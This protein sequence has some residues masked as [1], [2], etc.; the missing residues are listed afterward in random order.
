MWDCNAD[1]G[2]NLFVKEGRKREGERSIR[3]AP[4]WLGFFVWLLSERDRS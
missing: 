4:R 1:R 3:S 2:L